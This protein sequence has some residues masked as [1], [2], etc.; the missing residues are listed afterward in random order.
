MFVA[1]LDRPW[2][3]TPFL[4]QGFYIETADDIKELGKFC[5]HVFVDRDRFDETITVDKWSS[6]AKG[7]SAAQHSLSS[8][9]VTR[10]FRAAD[11]Q[12]SKVKPI[13]SDSID[14][15]SELVANDS[16]ARL[17]RELQPAAAAYSKASIVIDDVMKK[18][19]SGAEVDITTLHQA[20]DP[21]IESVMR[22]ED[23]LT[24]LTR[25]KKKDDYVFDHSLAASIWLTIFG[26][27]LGFDRGT[28]QIVCMGGL[29]LDVGKMKMPKELL[30]HKARLSDQEMALMRT[31]VEEGVKIVGQIE[32]IDQKILDMVATHHERHNGMGYPKGLEGNRIPIFGRIA[33][34]VDSYCAMTMNRPYAKA[35][36][37]N[38][39]MMQLNNLAG[40][41]FQAEMVEQFV[42]A[43]GIFPVGALVE[44]S[45]GEVGVVIAQN[46]IRRLRPEVM[47]LL[48]RDK[49]PLKRFPVI[50]LRS[51]LTDRTNAES[52]WITKG[53]PP[54]AYGVA[55]A[56]YYI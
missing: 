30:A 19:D 15:D 43:I 22:N 17:K 40:A 48:D 52:L 47:I 12:T 13:A 18:I 37:A 55:P 23:A 6:A 31:H 4:F 26:K 21:M 27:H 51:Q 29:F 54:G 38:D 11:T 46:R 8:T 3:E 20:I 14:D 25:M 9:R 36:S 50:D 35:V 7:D 32:G 5:D 44:L 16:T 2:L 42:Q 28:L 1:E 24:W 34:I 10:L 39:A 56:N 45:T 49:K 33:G 41:E 53:L